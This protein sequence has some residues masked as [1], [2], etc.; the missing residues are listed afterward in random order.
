MVE[1]FLNVRFDE[2]G[3]YEDA[4]LKKNQLSQHIISFNEF[5]LNFSKTCV[6]KT[7]LSF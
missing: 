4:V 2:F 3:P 6:D 7:E 5:W 1:Q